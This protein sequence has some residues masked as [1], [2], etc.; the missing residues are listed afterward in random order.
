MQLT[1]GDCSLMERENPLDQFLST[2]SNL[3]GMIHDLGVPHYVDTQ[4]TNSLGL[5]D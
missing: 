5:V 2:G 4:V 1:T 3:N